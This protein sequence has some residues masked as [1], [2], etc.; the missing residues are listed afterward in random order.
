MAF[1]PRSSSRVSLATSVGLFSA[2]SEWH[3]P[4]SQSRFRRI[5]VP[6][7]SNVIADPH[8]YNL[9]TCGTRSLVWR[10]PIEKL[11]ASGQAFPNSS[12]HPSPT[13]GADDHDRM[14]VSK[15]QRRRQARRT[16][17]LP[18]RA[19]R[20]LATASPTLYYT[21]GHPRRQGRPA[22]APPI[23]LPTSPTSA[24]VSL[25]TAQDARSFLPIEPM[26]M[27]RTSTTSILSGRPPLPM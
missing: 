1:P 14:L 20:S 27:D 8:D 11:L 12:N 16:A 22:H 13:V 25:D 4:I 7:Y 23:L 9:T 2:Q 18:L 10:A 3:P 15:P 24:R 6:V 17:L 26:T 19:S 21:S 5:T